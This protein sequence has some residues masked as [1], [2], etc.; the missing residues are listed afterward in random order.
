MSYEIWQSTDLAP[1][2]LQRTPEERATLE[3]LGVSKNELRDRLKQGVK[4]RFASTC[5]DDALAEVGADAGGLEQAPGETEAAFRLRL[6]APWS[7]WPTAGTETGIAT[8][9]AATGVPAASIEVLGARSGHFHYDSTHWSMVWVLVDGTDPDGV[10][11]SV[12]YD[13]G[14]APFGAPGPRWPTWG[15]GGLWGMLTTDGEAIAGYLRRC[16]RKFRS[17]FEFPAWLWIAVND[18]TG[19]TPPDTLWGCSGTWGDGG[20]WTDTSCARVRVLVGNTWG[21]EAAG[22][23]PGATDVW[24]DSDPWGAWAS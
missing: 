2:W 15:D 4:A 21:Q 5:P 1:P 16:L 17:G 11:W 24:G 20:D 8:A 9:M 13:W 22:P 7:F 6:A 18:G 19:T 12:D 23:S 14:A 3:A 10:N